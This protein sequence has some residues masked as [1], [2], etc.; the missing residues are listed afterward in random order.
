MGGTARIEPAA[1]NG[2]GSHRHRIVTDATTDTP[3][4]SR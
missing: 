4:S 1:R 3:A 2:D